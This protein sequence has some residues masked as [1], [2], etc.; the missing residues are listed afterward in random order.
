MITPRGFI[1]VTDADDGRM[2][3]VPVSNIAR[4]NELNLEKIK[5]AI[6][7]KTAPSPDLF[8]VRTTEDVKVIAVLL[9]KAR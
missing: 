9:G 7:L 3:L 1:A 2:V 5:A 8:V 4:V 6:Q